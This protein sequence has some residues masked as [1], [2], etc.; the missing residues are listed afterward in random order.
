MKTGCFKC[1][2]ACPDD[3]MQHL[4]EQAVKKDRREIESFYATMRSPAENVHLLTHR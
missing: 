3:L 2:A 1:H 4:C